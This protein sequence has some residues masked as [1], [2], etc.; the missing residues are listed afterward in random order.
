MYTSKCVS[1]PHHCG[2]Q[3]IHTEVKDEPKEKRIKVFHFTNANG[4]GNFKLAFEFAAMGYEKEK[5]LPSYR[6]SDKSVYVSDAMKFIEY[7]N[8]KDCEL[9]YIYFIRT[10]DMSTCV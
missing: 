3:K 2:G 6:E 4:V 7:V 8:R 1:Q 10:E 5:Y 9:H